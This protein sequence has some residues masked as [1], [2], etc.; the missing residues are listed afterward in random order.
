M[1]R[2]TQEMVEDN[3]LTWQV[4]MY[5]LHREIDKLD[6]ENDIMRKQLGIPDSVLDPDS[7]ETIEIE[8]GH[9]LLHGG[10]R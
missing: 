7:L 3:L 4:A 5:E 10:N 9:N 8:I 1:S 6:Q 2:P